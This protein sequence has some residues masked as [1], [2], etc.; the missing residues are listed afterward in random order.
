MG[1]IVEETGPEVDL[2]GSKGLLKAE[3]AKRQPTD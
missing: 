1:D 3:D 2:G